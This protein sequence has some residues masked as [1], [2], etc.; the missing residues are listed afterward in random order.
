M[1]LKKFTIRDQSKFYTEE[2]A[3]RS[4]WIYS[5]ADLM[6]LLLA[7]FVVLFSISTIDLIKYEMLT[8]NLLKP[9]LKRLTMTDI[10]DMIKEFVENKNLEDEI[11]VALSQ[12]GVEISFKN[13][14]LFDSAEADLKE[15]AVQILSA[16]S[17]LFKYKEISSR[18]IIVEGHTD[19]IPMRSD[20][21]PSN[22]DLSSG[23]AASVVRFLRDQGL[24]QQRFESIGYADT[25]P[26]VE[27]SAASEN[28]RV[29]IVVS[30][31]SYLYKE[32]R[33]EI[34]LYSD[35]VVGFFG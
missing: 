25:H 24:N 17:E 11:D 26:I 30:P 5:Y 1:K 22:W 35:D 19:S 18:K 15:K 6:T 23:R 7:F 27:K 28:R 20:R 21:F 34:D 9:E 14:L 16:M 32:K 29:V 33:K 8:Q 31:N 2:N 12:K 10:K 4:T 13:N 3:I